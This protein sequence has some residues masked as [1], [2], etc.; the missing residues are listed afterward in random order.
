MR[1]GHRYVFGTVRGRTRDTEPS[2][3]SGADQGDWTR[4]GPAQAREHRA[5]LLDAGAVL[6]EVRVADPRARSHVHEA[7]RGVEQQLHVVTEAEVPRHELEVREGHGRVGLERR[8]CVHPRVAARLEQLQEP[9]E[10]GMGLDVRGQLQRID[11][12]RLV[13]RLAR[14]AVRSLAT[15]AQGP[16]T[17]L[18]SGMRLDSKTGTT[19]SATINAAAINGSFEM[20]LGN[21]LDSDGGGA[22][23]QGGSGPS[24]GADYPD[25]GQILERYDGLRCGASREP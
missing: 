3:P 19:S 14:D 25:T 18:T 9:R 1:V 20:R 2:A 11:T 17:G 22:S 6:A 15:G 10:R 13:G 23:N 16:S 5:Q 24:P 12:V 8:A 21:G 7:R 4:S